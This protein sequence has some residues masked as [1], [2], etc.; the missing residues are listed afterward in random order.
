MILILYNLTRKKF[1]DKNKPKQKLIFILKGR[2]GDVIVDVR[3]LRNRSKKCLHTIYWYKL[4]RG[5][6]QITII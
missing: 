4:R 3:C 2:T 6:K 1:V 5:L